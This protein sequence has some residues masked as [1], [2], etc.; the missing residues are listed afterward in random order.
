MFSDT[1]NLLGEATEQICYVTEYIDD[2]FV[3]T[4]YITIQR[5]DLTFKNGD[6][7]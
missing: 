6:V 2:I 1:T 7:T 3:K 5:S 4:S